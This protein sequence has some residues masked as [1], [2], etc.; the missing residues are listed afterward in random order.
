MVLRKV[1]HKE[2]TLERETKEEREIYKIGGFF[3]VLT[4]KMVHKSEKINQEM[5]TKEERERYDKIGGFIMV[6]TT[7]VVH[8]NYQVI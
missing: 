5:E 7:I 8:N 6:S 4:R 3:M 1:V 2:I